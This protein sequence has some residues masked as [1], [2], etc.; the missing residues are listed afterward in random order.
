MRGVSG[1]EMGHGGWRAAVPAHKFIPFNAE[2]RSCLGKKVSVA[3]MKCVVA[4]VLWNLDF[5]VLQGHAGEPKLSVVLQMKKGLMAKD[6]KR[7]IVVSMFRI[8]TGAFA[9]KWSVLVV[10]QYSLH[11]QKNMSFRTRLCLPRSD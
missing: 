1:G 9:S 5:M 8:I 3:Q 10:I 6:K 7:G 4:A 2:L 11:T